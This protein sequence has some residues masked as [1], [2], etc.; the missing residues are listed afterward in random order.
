MN[1]SSLPLST[2]GNGTD[3]SDDYDELSKPDWQRR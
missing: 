1:F 2:I 3:V